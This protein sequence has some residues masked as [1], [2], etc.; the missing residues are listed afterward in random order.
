MKRKNI[1]KDMVY[2]FTRLRGHN[3]CPWDKAQ[4]INS[5]KKDLMNEVKE[6]INAINKKDI[7]NF[8]EELGD[9]LWVIFLMCQIAKEKGYFTIYDVLKYSKKKIINRHPHVFGNMKAKTPEEALKIFK[10]MKNKEK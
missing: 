9:V 4:T 3:G 10:E 1:L 6:V 7:E 5:L 2:I 8:K